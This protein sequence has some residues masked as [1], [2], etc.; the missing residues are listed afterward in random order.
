M[1]VR[2]GRDMDIAIK[3]AGESDQPLLLDF[4]AVPDRGGSVRLE[5][6]SLC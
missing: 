2:W 5:A 1:A 3:E 6:E 4:S